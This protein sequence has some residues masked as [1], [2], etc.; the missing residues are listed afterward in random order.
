[1]E[2][3]ESRLPQD[4][5]PLIIDFLH[6]YDIA[7]LLPT[8]PSF[9]LPADPNW[10]NYGDHPYVLVDSVYG[11]GV[12]K[13]PFLEYMLQAGADTFICDN[14]VY[15]LTPLIHACKA[16]KIEIVEL[17]IN[18]GVDVN[19]A[20][21]RGDTPLMWAAA[22]GHTKIVAALLRAGAD[23]NIQ[24]AAGN[25][26]LHC[27]CFFRVN[28]YYNVLMENGFDLGVMDD[29]VVKEQIWTRKGT[30][31][32]MLL[33]N[34]GAD[35]NIENEV[36]VTPLLFLCSAPWPDEPVSIFDIL[37][38]AGAIPDIPDHSGFTAIR[39]TSAYRKWNWAK[40]LAYDDRHWEYSPSAS[41]LLQLG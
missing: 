16:N 33:E 36:G 32:Q 34:G 17:L 12:S 2:H 40:R 20:D 31:A 23:A 24:G 18:Y 4:V 41:P 38:R 19:Y 6:A 27:C 35:P 29:S 28:S 39:A 13:L 1:M 30:I 8:Y 5:L 22:F 9:P 25:T 37:L 21:D 3:L 11:R 14:Y 7:K 15:E 26:A 10:I